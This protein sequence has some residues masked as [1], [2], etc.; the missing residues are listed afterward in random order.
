MFAERD[1]EVLTLK[2]RKREER[3]PG[4]SSVAGERI[5][6]GLLGSHELR[7]AER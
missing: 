3:E 7:V 1:G 5:V 4:A 6:V 2:E